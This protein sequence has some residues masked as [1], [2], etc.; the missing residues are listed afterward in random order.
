MYNVFGEKSFDQLY[1]PTCHFFYC[2]QDVN[3]CNDV[4][5]LSP[6][7]SGGDHGPGSSLRLVDDLLLLGLRLQDPR[8]LLTLGNVDV[9]SLSNKK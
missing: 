1:L 2:Y 4:N 8:L 7:L 5:A 9:G 6:G 3:L